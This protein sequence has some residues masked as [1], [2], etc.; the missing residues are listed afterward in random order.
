MGGVFKS[1]AIEAAVKLLDIFNEANRLRSPN[2]KA[3]FE[4]FYNDAIN[5]EVSL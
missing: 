4:D 1:D 3:K 2:E 5:K